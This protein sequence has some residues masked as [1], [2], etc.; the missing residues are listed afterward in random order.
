M[1]AEVGLHKLN[2][3]VDPQL[4][5]AWF[6]PLNLS[7]E[8]PVSIF[9]AFKCNLVPLRRGPLRRGGGARAP[10]TA[11]RLPERQRPPRRGCTS[12][13]IALESAWFGDSTLEPI[14]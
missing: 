8:N 11:H 3:V 6:Q 1:H 4:E 7:I 14:E 10:R 2:P 12:V 5:S 9:A 13:P